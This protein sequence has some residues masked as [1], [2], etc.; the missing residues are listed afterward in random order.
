MGATKGLFRE[1][2]ASASQGSKLFRTNVYS[3]GCFGE[4]FIFV[5]VN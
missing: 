3:H 2:E 1:N 4:N 5:G